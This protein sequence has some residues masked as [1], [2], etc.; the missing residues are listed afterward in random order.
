M[1]RIILKPG[2]CRRV[3]AGHP[4]IF[5]NEI[6]EIAG[7]A[8]PGCPVEVCSSAGQRFGVGYYNPHSLI[9]A[10]L[11]APPG[12]SIDEADFFLSRLRTAIDYRRGVYPDCTAVR[13]VYGESDGLPGL[14]V[15]RYGEVL[16][17][18]LL[19]LG[20]DLRR[21]LIVEALTG[22]LAPK[23][24]LARNDVA[25]RSL[26]G[27][28]LQVELLDG[29]LPEEVTIFEHGLRF[30]VDL[31]GGQKTG[32]FLDQRENHTALRGRV[33][34]R[35]VLD[36]FC[37]S[38]SWSIHAGR[39]GAAEVT[40]VDISSGAI[41]L[42]RENAAANY[43]DQTCQFEQADVFDYLR[44]LQQRKER[45]GTIVLDPPAFVKNKKKLAEAMRGYL[46]VNL[47]AM[48]LLEPGGYLLTCSCSHHL[49]RDMFID[50]LRKGARQAGRQVH[51]LEMRGQAYDHPVLLACPETDYLK[52]A[53]LRVG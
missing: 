2:H 5:S 25:V 29:A 12:T 52:C 7:S 39:Y 32:H 33:E 11:L 17:V 14:V 21:D 49:Q 42:A 26:E 24:I 15:D 30:K 53:V 8:E 3:Q 46:T 36:L 1:T 50:L 40:G 22:L 9:S 47:R 31:V 20:M 16:V 41:E 28:P 10:R 45:F 6:A 19:T 18:Q 27:L 43:L 37:Y 35:R 13:L 48:Q 34:G 44:N 23:A 38:G 4:W 51:L